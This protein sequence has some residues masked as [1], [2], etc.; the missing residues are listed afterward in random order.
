MPQITAGVSGVL[1]TVKQAFAG[2]SGANREI[3]DGYAGVS[4][5]NR[6]VFS[7]KV[8]AVL[9]VSGNS[10]GVQNGSL[11][12]TV[13]RTSAS[14]SY[15]STFTV[16]F[17][18][19]L[20]F[21]NAGPS[22]RDA[23][24]YKKQGSWYYCRHRMTIGSYQ[25]T[26]V[27]QSKSSSHLTKIPLASIPVTTDTVSFHISNTDVS[28]NTT[29]DTEMQFTQFIFYPEEYPNGLE[30]PMENLVTSYPSSNPSQTIEMRE[31]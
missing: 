2:V 14:S 16:K 15:T 31:L 1:R 21:N 24:L 17:S 22:G 28:S 29:S 19:K 4:G 20:T 8:S 7:G 9:S 27:K 26:G 10:C 11:Y 25:E 12:S 6:P 30:I 18:K 3:R 5:V 13:N 23:Y